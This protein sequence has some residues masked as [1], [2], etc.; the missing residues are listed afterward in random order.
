MNEN[1]LHYVWVNRKLPFL[2]L[3]TTSGEYLEILDYGQYLQLSG[4]D[5]FNAKIKI[6]NQ[7]WAGN[8]EI[9]VKSSDWYLHQHE[10][11]KAYETI[12]LHVVWEYDTPIFRKDN[13]EIHTL[14]LKN[15]VDETL[16]Q[17]YANLLRKKTWIN[18]ENSIGTIEP[19]IFSKWKEELVLERL[20]RKAT[21]IEFRLSQTANNWD[22]VFFENL[23]KGFGLNTNGA[24]FYEMAKQLTYHVVRKERSD[25]SQIEALF[26]GMLNLLQSNCEEEYFKELKFKWNYFKVKY[27][28]SECSGLEVAFFKHRPDNFPTIR[29]AQLAQLLVQYPNLFDLII[30]A[31]SIETIKHILKVST[32][33]FWITHYNFCKPSVKKNKKISNAFID[34]I[35][36]NTIIPIK[37]AYERYLGKQ[38]FEYLLDNLRGIPAESNTIINHFKNF[39]IEIDSCFD[40]QALLQLKNEFCNK[41]RC[42]SCVIGLQI[43]KK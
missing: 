42:L 2:N 40:S 20:V 39:N 25:I 22:Q 10:K 17:N 41:N 3:Q 23:A 24:V 26:F 43:V 21:E 18:C 5:I 16:I 29:L 6:G 30:Q 31:K 35:L 34:L 9:H 14:E 12:I 27:Q 32:H 4:P 33:D 15:I 38:D 11:D 36:I 37:F 19:F 7:I 8:I 28:L 1:F 13:S